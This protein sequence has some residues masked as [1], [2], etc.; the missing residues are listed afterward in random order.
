M[1]SILSLFVHGWVP[2]SVVEDDVAGPREVEPN[3]PGPGA[4]D[5]TKHARVVVESF[6]DSLSELCLGVAV[7]SDVVELEHVED[8]LEDV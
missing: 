6:D 4:A 3:S 7:K 8:L 1:A 2:V 5:E